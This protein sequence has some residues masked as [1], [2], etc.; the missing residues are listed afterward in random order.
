MRVR[1]RSSLDTALSVTVRLYQRSPGTDHLDE[2]VLA[3][4]QR[5]Q[6]GLPPLLPHAVEVELER[7]G[8]KDLP[9]VGVGW[10]QTDQTV[11][12]NDGDG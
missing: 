8:R 7:A 9:P 11:P 6:Q 4:P 12:G 2:A 10:L 5:P 3:L 1:G